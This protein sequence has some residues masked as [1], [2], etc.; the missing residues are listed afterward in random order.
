MRATR[1]NSGA[2]RGYGMLFLVHALVK[3]TRKRFDE[4][5]QF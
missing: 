3:A 1:G 2:M 4:P 5:A